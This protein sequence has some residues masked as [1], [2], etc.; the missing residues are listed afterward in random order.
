MPSEA[1][2]GVKKIRGKRYVVLADSKGGI[3]KVY[4]VR[5]DL[6][7]KGLRRWPKTLEGER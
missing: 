5:N 1:K 6:M 7:L 2:S 3:L 4:R